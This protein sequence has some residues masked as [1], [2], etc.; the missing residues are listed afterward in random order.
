MFSAKL[1]GSGYR[2][3]TRE[4]TLTGGGVSHYIA[5]SSAY[6]DLN[7][8]SDGTI[9]PDGGAGY[10]ETVGTHWHT[11]TPTGADYDVMATLDSGDT[12][13]GAALDTWHSLGSQVNYGMDASRPGSGFN[14]QQGILTIS[15]RLNASQLVVASNTYTLTA[16]STAN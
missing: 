1:L 6:V 5:E 2:N 13:S 12:P 7:F 15:I 11:G 14:N 9:D 3:A 10:T 8:E 16:N 4:E